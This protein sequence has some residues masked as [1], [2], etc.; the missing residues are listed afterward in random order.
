[1]AERRNDRKFSVFSSTDTHCSMVSR[2]INDFDDYKHGYM[3][4]LN[5]ENNST[6]MMMVTD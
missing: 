2:L 6:G 1:M 5:K 3:F 4:E